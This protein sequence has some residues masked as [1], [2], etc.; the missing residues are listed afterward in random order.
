MLKSQEVLHMAYYG[1]ESV[2]IVATSFGCL[3]AS[4]SSLIFV[5]AIIA[6]YHGITSGRCSR[7]RA[8]SRNG[9]CTFNFLEFII[10]SFL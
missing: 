4:L 9:G 7:G 10:I 1:L 2:E 3:I 8:S 6:A 5:A